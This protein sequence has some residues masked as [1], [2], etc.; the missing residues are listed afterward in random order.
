MKAIRYHRYGSPDELK[1][2]EVK[3]P[4]PGVNEVL[5][6]V[7]ASSINS[8]DW[9]LLVGE[10]WIVRIGGMRKPKYP[11]LGADVAGRIITQGIEATKFKTGDE[12]FGDLSA[13]GWGGFGEYVCVP[14]G[15][16]TLKPA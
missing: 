5:V 11:I 1:L 6:K 4:V 2:E 3:Q 14:E 8:W 15:V 13:S 16:L 12:V 7:Y 9:G 10:P